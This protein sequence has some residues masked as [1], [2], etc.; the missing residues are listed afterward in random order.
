MSHPTNHYSP[1]EE[2]R[3]LTGPT[4]IKLL[5]YADSSTGWKAIKRANI[6]FVRINSKRALFEETQVRAWIDRNTVNG[7]KAVEVAS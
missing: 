5:G 7:T 6:P 4:V 2:A 3:F 1:L